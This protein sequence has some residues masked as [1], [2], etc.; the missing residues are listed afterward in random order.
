MCADGCVDDCKIQQLLNDALLADVAFGPAHNTLGKVYLE[1]GKHY[2]AAWE[3]E[4]ANRLMP[5]RTEPINNLGLV[6]EYAGQ[7]D[8]AIEFYEQAY[9]D[10]PQTAQYLGNLL[11]ARVRRGDPI[12]DLRQQFED[13]IL[14]DKRRQW[15]DWA[16]KFIVADD[17]Q[18]DRWNAE[19]RFEESMEELPQPS[20]VFLY[21][22]DSTSE[23]GDV[24]DDDSL[25]QPILE[26]APYEP[27]S[28]REQ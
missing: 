13:L 20:D 4:Y 9:S 18:M 5:D 1:Q 15:Q 6:Y 26:S 2:L 7:L 14:L 12:S 25:I 8:R 3:F 16:R 21:E 24:E 22:S 11:R 23:T 10:S 17:V 27:N 19:S 28:N